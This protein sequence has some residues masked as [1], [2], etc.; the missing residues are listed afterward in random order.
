[1]TVEDTIQ[2]T[3][4][5]V[6]EATP[7]NVAPVA[8]VEQPASQ[9]SWAIVAMIMMMGGMFL[10]NA[11]IVWATFDR[12]IFNQ[13][14][15]VILAQFGNQRVVSYLTFAISGISQLGLVLAFN[16]LSTKLRVAGAEL[17]M[18]SDVYEQK[19]SPVTVTVDAPKGSPVVVDTPA[20][21]VQPP[22]PGVMPEPE[23]EEDTYGGTAAKY[24]G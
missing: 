7:G 16:K 12:I 9:S 18:G 17:S 11:Y 24:G 21:T 20:P 1:M 2:S 23:I 10:L 3:V 19:L 22:T 8:H 6:N 4:A 15:P 5:A 14:E 13:G